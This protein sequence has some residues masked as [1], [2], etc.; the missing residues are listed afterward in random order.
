MSNSLSMVNKK[1]K[2]QQQAQTTVLKNQE[3]WT[4]I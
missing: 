4:K 3:K 2:T 1:Q